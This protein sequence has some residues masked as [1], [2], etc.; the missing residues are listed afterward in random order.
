MCV[1]IYSIISC[2]GNIWSSV[3]LFT[4]DVFRT[5]WPLTT[6]FSYWL[7]MYVCMY[8]CVYVCVCV[9][10][11]ARACMYVMYVCVY[12]CMHVCMYVCIIKP[13]IRKQIIT[14]SEVQKLV[15]HWSTLASDIKS[16]YIQLSYIVYKTIYIR[17]S[18]MCYQQ[19]IKYLVLSFDYIEMAYLMFLWLC[20]VD[21][22]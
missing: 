10:V 4:R 1:L 6:A 8:V 12:V 17:Y 3:C 14:I 9:C 7:C 21:I 18:T 15:K 11:C 5:W 16:F 2:C 19:F 20:I 22:M 13:L